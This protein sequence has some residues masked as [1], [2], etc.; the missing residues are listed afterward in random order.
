MSK[1]NLIMK[2]E[3]FELQLKSQ[4]ERGNDLLHREVSGD[5]TTFV[6]PRRII[7]IEEYDEKEKKCSS[8]IAENGIHIIAH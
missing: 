4:I 2:R 8:K 1:G 5:K 7:E 3:D 6:H